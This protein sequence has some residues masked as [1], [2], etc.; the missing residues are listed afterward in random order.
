MT[1]S[2]P[3]T[4]PTDSEENIDTEH[5]C[6]G[7]VGKVTTDISDSSDLG[8]QD[9]VTLGKP[10]SASQSKSIQQSVES[11]DSVTKSIPP[12]PSKRAKKSMPHPRRK[13]QRC[14]KGSAAFVCHDC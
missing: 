6:E 2:K 3:E 14:M 13:C 1:E 12:L 10:S 11:W 9:Y 5:S 7:K 4:L 8:G